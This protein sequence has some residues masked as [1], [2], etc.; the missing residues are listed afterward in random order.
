VGGDRVRDM[1]GRRADKRDPWIRKGGQSRKACERVPER[2]TVTHGAIQ[3][4]REVK[5]N[6]SGGLGV[7]GEKKRNTSRTMKQGQVDERDRSNGHMRGL[8]H[9]EKR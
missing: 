8:W 1:V 6:G 2:G 4:P 7:G 5:E 3:E 9:R